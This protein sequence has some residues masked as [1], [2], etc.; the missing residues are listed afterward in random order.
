[1]ISAVDNN[2]NKYY[3][4]V[5]AVNMQTSRGYPPEFYQDLMKKTNTQ[6]SFTRQDDMPVRGNFGNLLTYGRSSTKN[7][8]AQTTDAKEFNLLHPDV[9]SDERAQIMDLMA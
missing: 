1:M 6:D 7:P 9:R 3:E 5:G 4:R 2:Q 8:F